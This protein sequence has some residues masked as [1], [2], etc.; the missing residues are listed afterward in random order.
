MQAEKYQLQTNEIPSRAFAK[1]SADL[2]VKLP[3]SHY[4]S[5]NIQVMVDHL[6]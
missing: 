2:I 5:E 6:T 3:T 4:N 1:V